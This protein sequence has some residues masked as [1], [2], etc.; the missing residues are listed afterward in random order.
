LVSGRVDQKRL[1]AQALLGAV[2]GCCSEGV[3]PKMPAF[4]FQHTEAWEQVVEW[5]D[6]QPPLS[7]EA[8]TV[9]VE[10]VASEV[11]LMGEKGQG[12]RAAGY[13]RL[14]AGLLA[15]RRPVPDVKDRI[16]KLARSIQG[17]F[18]AS[19][20]AG[21]RASETAGGSAR[22]S[23]D[24]LDD[25]RFGSW[26]EAQGLTRETYPE[27]LERQSEL[28]WLKER[29]QADVGRYI[30]DELRCRG[31]YVQ[32]A[33]RASEKESLLTE[34]GMAEPCLRDVE[35]TQSELFDWYFEHRLGRRVLHDLEALVIDGGFANVAMAE[36]EALREMLYLKL[37]G[38]QELEGREPWD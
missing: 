21:E 35:L 3:A 29:Y 33:Q 26:L 20:I 11:R 1:D 12:I 4:T 25:E 37:G 7:L 27:L 13:A 24:S 22:E 16:T 32:V 2:R 8:T 10:L 34:H 15:R 18:A 38:G 17:S 36:R 9:P 5:A 6:G 23:G 14:A 31:E 28:N 30:I 19:K